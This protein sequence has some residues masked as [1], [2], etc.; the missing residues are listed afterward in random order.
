MKISQLPEPYK[1]LALANQKAQGTEVN[2]DELADAFLWDDSKQGYAFWEAINN[3]TNPYRY[4][5]TPSVPLP[6]QGEEEKEVARL[7][8]IIEYIGRNAEKIN[9]HTWEVYK[10]QILLHVQDALPL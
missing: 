10:E 9:D 3:G 8:Q 4:I 7:R 2:T 5:E 1:S 6:V